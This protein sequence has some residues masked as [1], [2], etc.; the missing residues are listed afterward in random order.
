MT[1]DWWAANVPP[2]SHKGL[3]HDLRDAETG[4]TYEGLPLYQAFEEY[5]PGPGPAHGVLTADW[6]P[7]D[8]A[9]ATLQP[10]FYEQHHCPCHRAQDAEEAGA[11]VPRS[12]PC[13][14]SRFLLAR[15]Y[16]PALSGLVLFSETLTEGELEESL[17]REGNLYFEG[18][19]S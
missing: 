18:E 17:G 13:K 15:V 11:D 3:R 5:E 10:Y 16:H 9:V 12:Y 19:G 8:V 6:E 1:R 14:G 7:P 2:G 4:R